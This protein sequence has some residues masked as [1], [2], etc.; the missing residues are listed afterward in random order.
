M[1]QH[2]TDNRHRETT[3]IVLRVTLFRVENPDN[4]NRKA[5]RNRVVP[6]CA[7]TEPQSRWLAIFTGHR[8]DASTIMTVVHVHEDRGRCSDGRSMR[9]ELER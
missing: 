4:N 9:D 6:H 8:F 2:T 7:A 1:S 3:S 5:N